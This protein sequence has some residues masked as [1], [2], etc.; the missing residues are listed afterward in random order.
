M[1]PEFSSPI[2]WLHH[3]IVTSTDLAVVRAHALTLLLM[4][5]GDQVQDIYQREMD[6]DG[7]F[8][9]GIEGDTDNGAKS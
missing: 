4:V 3:K 8:D 2:N 6:I 1:T 7:Y 5:D 9:I